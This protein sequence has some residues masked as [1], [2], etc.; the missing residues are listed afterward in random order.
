MQRSEATGRSPF[1]LVM[2][3]HPN[4]PQS[5]P[6]DAGFKSL[7]AYQMAKAW[8]EKV[9]LARSYLDKAAW[10]MKKFADRKRRPMDYQIEDRVMV[11]LNPRQFKSLQSVNQNLIRKYEGP[12]E[13]TAKVGKISYRV[14]MPHHLKKPIKAL[15][16]RQGRQ[17]AGAVRESQN[18]HHNAYCGQAN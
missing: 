6:V 3:Q 5:F 1:E 16:R 7:G 10:K 11:K 12:F 8:E 13:I 2:G 14:D 9:D 17:R 4:T 18:L 15:F